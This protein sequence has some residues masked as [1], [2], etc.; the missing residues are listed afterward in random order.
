MPKSRWARDLWLPLA[1]RRVGVG[2]AEQEAVKGLERGSRWQ[3]REKT[4]LVLI[5]PSWDG[6]RRLAWGSSHS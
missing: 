3:G 5:Q 2:A 1:E 6:L 4:K